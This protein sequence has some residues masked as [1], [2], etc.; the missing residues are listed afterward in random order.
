MPSPT[1]DTLNALFRSRPAFAVEIVRQLYDPDISTDTYVEVAS[2]EFNDRP[3]R[4]FRADTVITVGPPKNPELG[5]VIEVQLAPSDDK[6]LA[7]ARYAAALWLRVD[8][9]V[10][11]L[12]ICTSDRAATW[13][14][15]PIVTDLPGFTLTPLVLGPGQIP[16]ITDPVQAAECLEIATVSVMV[17]G[18]HRPVV[19][20]FVAAL[21]KVGGDDAPQ[22]YEYA[23]SLASSAAKQY[24]EEIMSSTTW[25]VYSPFAR[26]HFGKGR[27]EGEAKGRVEGEIDALFTVLD[28]RGVAMTEEARARITG[29]TDL[30]QVQRWI[31]RAV[32]AASLDD[33]FA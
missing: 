31:R 8:C 10:V 28:A 17:H 15:E 25:P 6:R 23:Y 26:A 29:C 9:P 11:V 1:H 14:A 13:A 30:S 21:T 19:E 16:A 7:W 33:L 5:I 32:T 18:G 24:L 3:S 20:A 2:A 12:V 27:E 22:Y 4:D